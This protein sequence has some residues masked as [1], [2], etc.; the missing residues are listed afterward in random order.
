VPKESRWP[1]LRDEVHQRVG[2]AIN[3]ALGELERAN[4]AT[5]GGVLDHIDFNRQVGGR[6]RLNDHTMRNLIQHFG[7]IPL[8]DQDLEF[9]DML[10][11]AYEYLIKFFAD[12]AGK[13]GG[14]FYTPREVV[15]LMVH[16]LKPGENMTVYDPCCGSGGMLILSREYVA[17]TGGDADNFRAYGQEANGNVWTICK[18]NLL[19]NSIHDAD[20]RL[21]DTLF[22]PQHTDEH[23]ELMRFDRVI[24]NPP[25]SQNYDHQ[26]MAHADRFVY[27]ETP[28]KGK[29]ADLM[30]LQHM[31]AVLRPAGRMATV[32]PHGVLFRGGAEQ[33]IRANLLQDDALEAVIGLPPNLFYGTGIPAC[34]LVL[35]PPHA[36]PAERKGKVLFINADAEYREGRAQNYLRPEHIEKIVD[37]FNTFGDVPR[38][39]RVVDLAELAANNHNLNIRRY[40][41]NAPPPEPHD[42]RAHLLG[43]VPL[44]EVEAQRP[45]FD[46]V[47]LD[48]SVVFVPRTNDKGPMTN[49]RPTSSVSQSGPSSYLDFHPDL[50]ARAAIKP[51]VEGAA[52]VVEQA[53]RLDRAFAAWWTEQSPRLAALTRGESLFDVRAGLLTTFENALLPVGLLDRFQV[54]GVVAGWWGDVAY[55]LKIIAAQGTFDALIESWAESLRAAIEDEDGGPGRNGD[56]PLAHPLVPRLLPRYLQE[57]D[58]LESQIAALRGQIAEATRAPDDADEVERLTPEQIKAL[59]KEL[60]E[61]RRGL[62]A[63]QDEFLERLD[64]KRAALSETQAQAVVLEIERERLAADLDRYVAARRGLLVAALENWWDKY[65]VSLRDVEAERDAAAAKLD[66]FARE[67]GYAK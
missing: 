57:L 51:C 19:F 7:K 12:S 8:R 38:Y 1:Y 47:G 44:A 64:A 32:M 62:K 20:I 11:A 65:R 58:A 31:L 18:M 23:N 39:A 22:D 35:R 55:D 52:G 26:G 59:R 46:A 37:T 49:A 63:L 21:A 27:G 36:K 61:T 14:E 60:R 6:P 41:D 29:K 3:I 25:F 10:G 30:F 34:I 42:V 54:D 5:L 16:L 28:E 13:K 45:F 33:K 2:D 9:P 53:E 66:E 4:S 15:R 43:G 48:P 17:E 67:L 24:S 56:D 40:A 50:D